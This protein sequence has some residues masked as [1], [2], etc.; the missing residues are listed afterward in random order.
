MLRAARM[1]RRRLAKTVAEGKRA[2]RQVKQ[3]SAPAIAQLGYRYHGDALRKTRRCERLNTNY[4]LTKTKE[5]SMNESPVREQQTTVSPSTTGQADQNHE[6]EGL[7]SAFGQ[8]LKDI[9]D[10]RVAKQQNPEMLAGL[11]KAVT[12]DL[13][14]SELYLA[15]AYLAEQR[16]ARGSS[17]CDQVNSQGPDLLLRFSKLIAQYARLLQQSDNAERP[18]KASEEGYKAKK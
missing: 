11:L 6:A 14:E 12:S 13:F 16:A 10:F 15:E 2:L 5:M 9:Q 1:N 17:E 18:Q 7:D 4:P 3:R 8:R